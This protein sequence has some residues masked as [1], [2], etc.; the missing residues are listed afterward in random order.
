MRFA[1]T[2]EQLE[3]RDAVATLLSSLCPP[4]AIRAA[5]TASPGLLDR[6]AWEALW[7][8]G[9]FE[10]LVPEA[11]GG[12]G[13][14]WCSLVLVLEATGRAGLPHPVI[15]TAAIA[16]PLLAGH[17]AGVARAPMISASL[18]GSP[19]VCGSDADWLVIDHLGSLLLVPR[20][21]VS[22][23]EIESVDRARRLRA[24]EAID[25]GVA[26]VLAAGPAALDGALDRA[27]LGAAAQLLGLSQTML[28]MTVAHVAGRH[29]F[30]VPVGSFQAVKHRLAD[31]LTELSFARPV[32]YRA[33][34]SLSVGDSDAPAHVSMA[35]AMASDTAEVVGRA[36]LQCHGAIGYSSEYDLHLFLKRA[37]ALS[38]SW[39]S[40][41]WHRRR[42][43]VG[44][45]LTL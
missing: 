9:V 16:S 13:L 14:D 2:A 10:V 3:L 34:W 11:A 24:V 25:A 42:V 23:A 33:A 41:G 45:G 29:Q 22:G 19:A 44:A 7:E 37:W 38:R 8:M 6:T 28:D 40:A 30:G 31:A 18:A 12:L 15:E 20:A 43:A 36:A 26:E 1:F 32:V 35:K 17:F 27:A 21:G 39:G 4:A 5:W